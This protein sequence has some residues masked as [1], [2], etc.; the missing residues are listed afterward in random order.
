MPHTSTQIIKN[1]LNPKFKFYVNREGSIK[2][3]MN[4]LLEKER[5]KDE[6]LGACLDYIRWGA[7]NTV[8]YEMDTNGLIKFIRSW[9]KLNEDNLIWSDEPPSQKFELPYINHKN[10]S[11]NNE[12][13]GTITDLGGRL[14]CAQVTRKKKIK[15]SFTYPFQVFDKYA[16][17]N[18]LDYSSDELNEPEFF[19]EDYDEKGVLDKS[20]QKEL[21]RYRREKEKFDAEEPVAVAD[22]CYAIISDRGVVLP[23]EKVLDRLN[24]LPKTHTVYCH[25]SI[26]LG[27]ARVNELPKEEREW[28]MEVNI[29]R[30]HE[31]PTRQTVHPFDGWTLAWYIQKWYEQVP[32]GNSPIFNKEGD[33]DSYRKFADFKCIPAEE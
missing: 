11:R 22:Y 13:K 4:F 9:M 28:A 31:E 12:H 7:P 29:C 30:G 2:E 16:Q 8:M 25:S 17:M 18:E 23:L 27:C 3:R 5:M 14:R 1:W 19:D 26:S 24:I 20:R 10:C 32:G 6:Y 15:P 33:R 21:E